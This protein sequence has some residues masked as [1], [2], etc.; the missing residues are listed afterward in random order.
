MFFSVILPTFNSSSFID[1]ALQSLMS[2][3]YRKFE[4][5]ASDDGSKDNTVKILKKY[6]KLFKK[7]KINLII[8]EN[9]HFGPGYARNKAI[10]KSKYEWL[11]FLDSD[12]VWHKD[13]LLKVLKKKNKNQ[14][15]NC[16][17]HNEIYINRNKKKIYYD[18][19]NMFSNNKSIFEQLFYQNFLSPTSTCI[20]KSL[21]EKHKMFD[22]SLPNGQDYDLWLKIGN[23]LKILKLDLYLAYYHERQDNIS[24]RPYLLRIKNILKIVNRYK[25]QVSKSIYFCKIIK[26]F[27]SKEWFRI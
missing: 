2:Q 26:L 18:Y 24:S 8:I 22:A 9:S 14:K 16:I 11:A 19:T 17:I 23:E 3:T 15:I 20:K 6:K 21:V 13:K 7:K 1:K 5:I 25:K 27:I 12:D 4:V 10:E